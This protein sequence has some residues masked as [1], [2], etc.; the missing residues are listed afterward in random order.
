MAGIVL[1][2]L[3]TFALSPFNMP[4]NEA[5]LSPFYS[6]GKCGPGR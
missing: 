1:S 4:V 5:S 6:G 2:A 3:D